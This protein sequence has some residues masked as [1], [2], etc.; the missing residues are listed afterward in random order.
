MSKKRSSSCSA[1]IQ[2]TAHKFQAGTINSAG[3]S[4]S[5]ETYNFHEGLKERRLGAEK[6]NKKKNQWSL[7][8]NGEQKSIHL[9]KLRGFSSDSSEMQTTQ[10]W[11]GPR[12]R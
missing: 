10:L 9:F 5:H 11:R 2:R 12:R 6:K 7:F 8:M 1:A 3:K 4:V